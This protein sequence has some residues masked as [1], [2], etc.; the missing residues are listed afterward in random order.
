[1]YVYVYDGL[2]PVRSLSESGS[3]S[4]SESESI[5]ALMDRSNFTAEWCQHR[6]SG[7]RFFVSESYPAVIR[8]RDR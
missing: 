6:Y 4:E 1:M 3:G 5:P 7:T 8:Y 2:P